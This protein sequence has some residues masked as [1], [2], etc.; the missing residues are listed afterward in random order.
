VGFAPEDAIHMVLALASGS[1]TEAEVGKT[2][3]IDASAEIMT[4]NANIPFRPVTG[5]AE[6]G[7]NGWSSKCRLRLS[8][9]VRAMISAPLAESS[10]TSAENILFCIRMQMG[11]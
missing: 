5:L 11:E 10:L 7:Q 4:S 9:P 2:G 1:L 6:I 8:T 3:P